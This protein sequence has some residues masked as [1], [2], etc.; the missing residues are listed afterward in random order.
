MI[1]NKW[2]F[3]V[4]YMGQHYEEYHHAFKAIYFEIT[5]HRMV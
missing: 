5:F 2:H 4:A 1:G 3:Q